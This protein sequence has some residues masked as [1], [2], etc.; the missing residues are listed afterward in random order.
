MY[1]LLV[2]L[3]NGDTGSPLSTI[4]Y[5][6]RLVGIVSWVFDC[7]NPGFPGI[8]TNVSAERD[9]IIHLCSAQIIP[10][11]ITKADAIP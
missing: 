4:S 11:E 8:Y 10:K 5:P 1:F 7:G 2:L 3:L 9:W 6:P